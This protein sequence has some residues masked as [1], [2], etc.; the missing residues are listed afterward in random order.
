MKQVKTHLKSPLVIRWFFSYLLILILSVAAG[1]GSSIYARKVSF[2]QA[3]Q[4]QKGLMVQVQLDIDATANS[5]FNLLHRITFNKNISRINNET[6]EADRYSIYQAAS[7]FRNYLM[8]NNSIASV[9]LYDP[10]EDKILSGAG[11]LD[12]DYYYSLY[13]PKLD[14][15]FHLFKEKLMAGSYRNVSYLNTMD[16]HQLIAFTQ[17][18]IPSNSMRE[19]KATIILNP[20]YLIERMDYLLSLIHI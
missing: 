6:A 2:Q 1:L 17:K 15:G 9:F 20:E 12:A 13:Y 3:N 4:I 11:Y 10:L 16:G 5:I 18:I 7:D 14:G 8:E 19:M